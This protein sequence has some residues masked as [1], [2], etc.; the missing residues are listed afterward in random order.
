MLPPLVTSLGLDSLAKT[1]RHKL[2]KSFKK[3]MY[4]FLLLICFS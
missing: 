1:P 4:A 3:Y 2:K